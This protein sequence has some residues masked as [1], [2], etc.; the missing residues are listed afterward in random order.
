[1]THFFF[2]CFFPPTPSSALFPFAFF[3]ALCPVFVMLCLHIFHAWS[4]SVCL[5]FYCHLLNPSLWRLVK[6]RRRTQGGERGKYTL[7]YAL[8]MF[9]CASLSC[10][11]P[12]SV[13]RLRFNHF[14]TECN[15]DHMYIYDGD[16]IYAPLVAVFRWAPLLWRRRRPG[17]RSSFHHCWFVTARVVCVCVISET[18][19]SLAVDSSSLRCEEMRRFLKWRRRQATHFS[20]S[21]ATLRTTWQDL[22]YFTRECLDSHTYCFATSYSQEYIFSLVVFLNFNKI[23]LLLC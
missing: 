22:R 4:V 23:L 12:N 5:Q 10:R 9:E 8:L 1:M 13:L 17:M 11:S 19:I 2:V 3:F 14:A 18:L 21:S 7:F 6:W 16:S 15:W 20:T